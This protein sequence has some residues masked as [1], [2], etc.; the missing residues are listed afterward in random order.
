MNP[1]TESA[2]T[3]L[4]SYMGASVLMNDMMPLGTRGASTMRVGFPVLVLCEASKRSITPGLEAAD[5]V[6]RKPP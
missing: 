5:A 4:R 6:V 2:T 1:E 3:A